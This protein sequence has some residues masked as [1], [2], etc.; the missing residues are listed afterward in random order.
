MLGIS[1][2]RSKVDHLTW[3]MLPMCG[4]NRTM[5]VGPTVQVERL[6]EARDDSVAVPGK[7][8]SLLELTFSRRTDDMGEAPLAAIAQ[9]LQEVRALALAGAPK[10]IEG[11]VPV[12]PTV[13][14]MKG[15]ANV[16]IRGLGGVFTELY[17]FRAD[18]L[19]HWRASHDGS[20]GRIAQCLRARRC[21]RRGLRIR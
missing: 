11:A 10:S 15:R 6:V 12:I 20:A 4:L 2:R 9:D 3:G 13:V 7:H 8:V 21:S 17:V 1:K 19:A 14:A 5:S 18:L 16:A